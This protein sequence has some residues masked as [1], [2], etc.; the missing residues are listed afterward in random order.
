MGMFDSIRC[1]YPL[2]LPLEVVDKLPDIYEKEFQTKD[3]ENLLDYYILTEEGEILFHQKKYEWRDD[4]S[5]FLKGYMEVIEEEII[6]HP[7]HGLLNFYCYETVYSDTSKLSGYDISVD[8]MAKFN[9]G[10]LDSIEVLEYKVEDAT[11]RL[12]ELDQLFKEQRRIRNF[13]YNKYIFNTTAWNW[14]K[15][16]ILILP[17]NKTIK[18]LMKIESLIWKYL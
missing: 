4:D 18:F 16:K 2:P 9:N 11:E 1:D 13:W 8:Y 5:S 10:R 7:F 3:F 6:P 14:F 12:L 17:I 15:K